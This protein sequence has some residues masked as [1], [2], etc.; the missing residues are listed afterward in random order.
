[1]KTGEN[2]RKILLFLM[3]V[4][5]LNNSF[6]GVN[7]KNLSSL[8]IKIVSNGN[9]Y[10]LSATVAIDGVKIG[11]KDALH[12]ATK[13]KDLASGETITSSSY[14]KKPIMYQGKLI[15]NFEHF[16]GKLCPNCP[17]VYL[18]GKSV[19]CDVS[20]HIGKNKSWYYSR[21]DGNLGTYLYR[22]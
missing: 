10:K 21:L 15:Y 19:D 11:K 22:N 16:Y 18:T 12:F 6:A 3:V 17:S 7:K 14:S 1:M 8:D 20:V 13:C 2:M 5:G 4:M 9:N